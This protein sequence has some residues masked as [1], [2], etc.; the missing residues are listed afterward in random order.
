VL[1]NATAIVPGPAGSVLISDR[2]QLWQFNLK[3][4]QLV[5]IIKDSSSSPCGGYDLRNRIHASNGDALWCLTNDGVE[6][7][8]L[9]DFETLVDTSIK[10]MHVSA[11]GQVLIAAGNQSVYR[12]RRNKSRSATSS[13]PDEDTP[14][15]HR[16][17]RC[18]EIRF[19]SVDGRRG[20]IISEY[21]FFSG[22]AKI[23]C[24]TPDANGRE[25]LVGCDN[26]AVFRFTSHERSSTLVARLPIKWLEKTRHK[27]TSKRRED[28]APSW[29][30]ERVISSAFSDVFI[31]GRSRTNNGTGGFRWDKDIYAL[32]AVV[33]GV[34]LSEPLW[35]GSDP[36]AS[37]A[38]SDDGSLIATSG[39]FGS[40][41]VFLRWNRLRRHHGEDS[42]VRFQQV[43][44]MDGNRAETAVGVKCTDEGGMVSLGCRMLAFVEKDNEC[45]V[46]ILDPMRP[47]PHLRK[48]VRRLVQVVSG[49]TVADLPCVSDNRL[50]R[51]VESGREL[52]HEIPPVLFNVSYQ[53]E[54][55]EL[56]SDICHAY[57]DRHGNIAFSTRNGHVYHHM[58]TSGKLSVLR[59]PDLRENGEPHYLYEQSLMIDAHGRVLQ[60]YRDPVN[61]DVWHLQVCGC[62][63]T[64]L[65]PVF[66]LASDSLPDGARMTSSSITRDGEILIAA[67]FNRGK[68]RM[69]GQS[70]IDFAH[71]RMAVFIVR[72]DEWKS[73]EQLCDIE[74]SG[75]D[76]KLSV[77]T[78]AEWSSQR[79]LLGFNNGQ[80]AILNPPESVESPKEARLV[81]LSRSHAPWPVF[82]IDAINHQ[83]FV[84]V[85]GRELQIGT[86]DEV[87]L[88]YHSDGHINDFVYMP[89]K[90]PLVYVNY[91]ESGTLLE[92]MGDCPALQ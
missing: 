23:T 66:S 59:E 2:D 20:V 40:H 6:A 45:R 73:V 79:L 48:D 80:I 58:A 57:R 29:Q 43:T 15:S 35:T 54:P 17:I 3:S 28:S 16:P 27:Q 81:W 89:G 50:E 46:S 55:R 83:C 44:L 78:I 75:P 7:T 33:S 30:I 38:C 4:T 87:L 92:V 74:W 71:G 64:L 37:L 49:A 53:H 25:I 1:S 51:I 31:V 32:W 39:D 24:L 84:S 67:T 56:T 88:E 9:C 13:G 21:G 76:A 60:W 14:T 72:P 61:R 65:K 77:T 34:L 70:K 82:K 26:G 8:I 5:P 10:G 91:G 69:Y 90:Q 12:W 52:L 19:C 11:R 18:P 47:V 62:G 63:D 41:S 36:I 22:E 86:A 68:R 85:S 42:S